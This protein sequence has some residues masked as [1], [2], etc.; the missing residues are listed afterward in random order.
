MGG[1]R[2]LS[3]S[4][5]CLSGIDP[6]SRFIGVYLSLQIGPSVSNRDLWSVNGALSLRN[7]SRLQGSIGLDLGGSVDRGLSETY[8]AWIGSI[9]SGW[10]ERA[11]PA[12]PFRIDPYPIGVYPIRDSYCVCFGCVGVCWCVLWRVVA[13]WGVLGCVG[14][15]WGVLGCVG[16]VGGCCGMLWCVVVL[17]GVVAC[18]GVL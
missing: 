11:M 13:C 16:C 1:D 2:P 12:M 14:V 8:F 4:E 15:Y 7:W 17:W 5:R 6:C 18:C 3:I 9:R 10:G